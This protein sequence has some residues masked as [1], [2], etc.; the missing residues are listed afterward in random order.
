MKYIVENWLTEETIKVFD[1]EEERQEW[2]NDNCISFSDGS[3]IDGTETKIS[4]YESR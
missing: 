1:S 4:I 3:Y 2:I